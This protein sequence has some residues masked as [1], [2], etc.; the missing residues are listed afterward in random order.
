MADLDE[1]HET[2]LTLL[3]RNDE[4]LEGTITRDGAAVTL[5]NAALTML[6]KPSR[7]TP[8]DDT[9]VTTLTDGAGITLGPSTGAYTVQVPA[10]ALASAG[11][12]WYR[13]DATIS[14]ARRTAIYGPL[15]VINT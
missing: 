14:G 9:T 1:P 8:D 4:T 15:H 11:E 3:E 10:A 13:V 5:D 12:H 6:I 7:H 2:P